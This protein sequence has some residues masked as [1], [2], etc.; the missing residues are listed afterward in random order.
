MFDIND[1]KCDQPGQVVEKFTQRGEYLSIG[2]MIKQARELNFPG[3]KHVYMIDPAAEDLSEVSE[4]EETSYSREAQIQSKFMKTKFASIK[5]KLQPYKGKQTIALIFDDKTNKI[6][7]KFLREQRR[8]EY[9]KNRQSESYTATLSHEMRTPI[10]N[11]IFF[12]L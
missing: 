10:M 2:G 7:E 12:L 1:V 3:V 6:R 9:I 11:I 4:Q 8:E 5:I